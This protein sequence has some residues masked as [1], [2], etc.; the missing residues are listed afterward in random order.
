MYVC[1]YVCM[2]VDNPINSQT[3]LDKHGLNTRCKNQLSFQ[4]QTSQLFKSDYSGVKC[5]TV[6]PAMFLNLKNYRK[7]SKNGIF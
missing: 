2:Y 3:G 7:Q 1:V 4:L 6:C 5:I